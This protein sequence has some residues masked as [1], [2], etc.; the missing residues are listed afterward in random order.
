M[1]NVPNSSDINSL[2]NS[3]ES[4]STIVVNLVNNMEKTISKVKAVE[5]L[6]ATQQTMG[7]INS[8]VISYVSNLQIII[9]NLTNIKS[10]FND[11]SIKFL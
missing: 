10:K 8:V 5:N 1:S 4:L 7:K 3:I 11:N 2:V 9:D 6:K